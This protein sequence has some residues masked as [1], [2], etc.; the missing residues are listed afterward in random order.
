MAA[1]ATGLAGAAIYLW[2]CNQAGRYSLYSEGVTAETYLR[3]VQEADADG[4]VTFTSISRPVTPVAGRTSTSSES[5]VSTLTGV[6]LDGDNV[7]SDGYSVR[8]ATVTGDVSSGL[9]AVLNVPV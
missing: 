2:H 8:L 3:G 9:T 5:S 1:G 7:F 4:Q 6:F